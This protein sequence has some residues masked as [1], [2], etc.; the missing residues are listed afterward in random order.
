M[1]FFPFDCVINAT[2]TLKIYTHQ[3]KTRD[4]SAAAMMGNFVES[5]LDIQPPEPIQPVFTVIKGGLEAKYG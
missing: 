5:A 2:T 3:F 1:F 4:A